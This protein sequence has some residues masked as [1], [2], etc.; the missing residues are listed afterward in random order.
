MSRKLAVAGRRASRLS[1]SL[2]AG[3]GNLEKGLCVRLRSLRFNLGFGE[4]G[5]NFGG[6]CP[7]QAAD[8]QSRR[9][10]RFSVDKRNLRRTVQEREEAV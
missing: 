2:V 6:V 4:L 8:V 10:R 1:G 7:V 9:T 3:K 5:Q